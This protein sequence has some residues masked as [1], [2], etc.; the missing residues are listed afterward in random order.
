MKKITVLE[1]IPFSKEQKQRLATLGDVEYCDYGENIALDVAM[2]KTKDSDVVLVNWID[3]SPFILSLKSNTLVGLLSTSYGWIQNMPKAKKQGTLVSNIPAYSTEAVAEHIF[4]L[5]LSFTKKIAVSSNQSKLQ[6]KSPIGTEL[7]GKS[8]GIIG[9]GNIGSRVAELAFAFGMSLLTYNRTSKDNTVAA[10]VTL[11][12]LLSMSDIIC[13]TCPLNDESRNLINSSNID[14]I[15]QGVIIVGATWG[16]IDETTL[17]N[18]LESGQIV[19]V[20]FDLALEGSEKLMNTDLLDLPNFVCT[21]HN[22]YNTVEAA[23][24]QRDICIK[25]IECFLLGKPQNVIN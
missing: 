20:T 24:R 3:P 5:L 17:K 10:N 19:G 25:N 9:M 6:K 14:F 16:V 7:K 8:I 15:N 4:G 11:N 12:E 13:I 23:E 22:A 1:S 18:A 21:F 2:E